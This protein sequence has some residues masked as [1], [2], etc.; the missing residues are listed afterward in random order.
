LLIV[1]GIAFV[2]RDFGTSSGNIALLC[3]LV[4]LGVAVTMAFRGG[5]WNRFT[6]TDEISGK[7]NNIHELEVKIGDRGVALSALRPAGSAMINDHRVEVHTEGE[8]LL[9][10]DKVEVIKRVQNKI[11]VK[12]IES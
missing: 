4:I 6:I 1:V 12:K 2:Y 10:N 9:T 11:I 3:S 8:F 5:A 7:A